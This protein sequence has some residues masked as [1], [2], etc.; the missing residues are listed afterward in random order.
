MIKQ[1]VNT[2]ENGKVPKQRLHFE[3]WDDIA[4]RETTESGRDYRFI[5][6]KEYR[7]VYLLMYLTAELSFPPKQ[8]QR[9][10]NSKSFS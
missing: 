2:N 5:L 4:D 7:I 10:H 3:G 9:Y 1:N 8:V 6:Y